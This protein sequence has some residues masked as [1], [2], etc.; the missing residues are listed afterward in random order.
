MK[1]LL[2]VAALVV[3]CAS[4]D[5]R[6]GV[7]KETGVGAAARPAPAPVLRRTTDGNVALSNLSGR[8]DAAEQ[9]LASQ[10]LSVALAGQAIDLY[11]TRSRFLGSFSDFARMDALSASLLE[12]FDEPEAYA[13][14][15][16]F[17]ATVHEFE[18][19]AGLLDQ[20]TARGLSSA[21][22]SRANIEVATGGDLEASLRLQLDRVALYPTFQAFSD[23]ALAQA[24]LGQFDEADSS[25][26][27]AA[28][29]YRDVSPLPLAF[30]AFARG[31]M[32]AES[33]NRPDFAQPLYVE[34]IERVPSFV[35][36][37]VH[38][39]EIEAEQ[40]DSAAA[41][42]RLEAVAVLSEDPEP[43]GLLAE[44]LQESDASASRRYADAAR[45]KYDE[46][47]ASYRLAFADHA[48]EFFAGPIGNEPQRAV[49][50][51]LDNLAHR[52]TPRAFIVAIEAARSTADQE[53]ICELAQKAAPLA[54]RSVNLEQLLADEAAA[55]SKVNLRMGGR[56]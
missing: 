22:R 55:C 51:S 44:L 31:V 16:S 19:A 56:Q 32:W 42:A 48:A 7:E 50:L 11:S 17:L 34:A 9:L 5:A 45:S 8:V 39:A 53:L 23:L 12:R 14:R 54:S 49:A 18:Q 25:Y 38:L 43:A 10:G 21:E 37:T 13:A 26:L 33:A 24:A 41:I 47:L 35:V 36:A 30:L 4:H 40:G 3:G 2:L 28:A 15:A 20:A 52:P 29:A 27:A 46:L 6:S 1:Q